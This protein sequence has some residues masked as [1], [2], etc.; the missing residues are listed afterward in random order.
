MG[1]LS[2]STTTLTPLDPFRYSDNSQPLSGNSL[3]NPL[4]IKFGRFKLW[5][6]LNTEAGFLCKTIKMSRFIILVNLTHLFWVFNL[7]FIILITD[8]AVKMSMSK[9]WPFSPFSRILDLGWPLLTFILTFLRLLMTSNLFI[10]LKTRIFC[11]HW[12]S[13]SGRFE[14]SLAK[15]C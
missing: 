10:D 3:I 14:I 12:F 11:G 2:Y 7:V 13:V 9:V 1:Q 4:Y 5:I 15:I 8:I 6:F